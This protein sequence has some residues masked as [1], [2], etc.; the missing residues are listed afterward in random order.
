[1]ANNKK[2]KILIVEDSSSLLDSISSILTQDGYEIIGA[3]EGK[4]AISV[5]REMH[6]DGAV[7]DLKLPDVNGIEVVRFLRKT[8]PDIS[9]IIMTAYPSV[10]TTVEALKEGVFDYLIKPFDFEHLKLVLKRALDRQNLLM[11]NRLLCESLK[12]DRE[13][14]DALLKIYKEMSSIFRIEELANFVIDKTTQIF[15]AKKGSF[16]LLDEKGESLSIKAA[17]GLSNEVVRKTKIEL[18][19]MLAGWVVQMGKPLLVKDIQKEF[20]HL[21]ERKAEYKTGSFIIMLLKMKDKIV[22]VINLTDKEDGEVFTEDDLKL[23]TLISH[24]VTVQMENI[25][26]YK[27][28]TFFSINDNLTGLFNHRHFQQRLD[29][30]INRAERYHRSLSLAILDIDDFRNYNETYGHL[31][32]DNVLKELGPILKEN[33]RMSDI[34]SRFGGEEFAIILPDT[35]PSQA[36]TAAE[37][38]RQRIEGSVFA[39]DRESSL[40]MARLTIS[41]GIA[42]YKTGISREELIYRAEQALL[43]AKRKGKNKVCVYK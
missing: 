11:K 25:K 38:I 29:E 35:K 28:A 5:A 43:G 42:F 30:E 19:Q 37:K 20:P 36:Q 39:T 15:K 2:E 6:L 4:D 18:G 3:R 27:E 17:N 8:F 21:V 40:G 41:A 22:G 23:L 14:L 31:M 9:V 33:I 12:E 34:P 26:L 1:M 7:V 32:G 13:R 10:E 24:L 16:M